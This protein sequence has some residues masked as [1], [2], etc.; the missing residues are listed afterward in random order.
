MT[1]LTQKQKSALTTTPPTTG[2]K[3]AATTDNVTTSPTTTK[4]TKSTSEKG[5]QT[6]G[7]KIL[8]VNNMKLLPRGLLPNSF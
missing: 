4:I 8:F 6:I 1:E 5:N 7:H 2:K 3:T